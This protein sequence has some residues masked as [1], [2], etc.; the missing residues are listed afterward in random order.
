MGFDRRAVNDS[1]VCGAAHAL[2]VNATIVIGDDGILH[3]EFGVGVAVGQIDAVAAGEV[4]G[5]TEVPDYRFVDVHSI[6]RNELDAVGAG[7]EAL[8]VQAAKGDD[9]GARGAA[10]GVVDV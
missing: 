1:S 5:G 3:H 2:G 7:A 6:S 4:A 8:D 10:A 9:G